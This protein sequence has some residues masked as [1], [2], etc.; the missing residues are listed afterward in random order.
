MSVSAVPAPY[1]LRPILYCIP[2]IYILGHSASIRQAAHTLRVC[3]RH[4]R[5]AG[6]PLAT[7][8]PRVA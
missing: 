8:T 6:R 1:V 5:A 2:A 3:A 4:A 7:E